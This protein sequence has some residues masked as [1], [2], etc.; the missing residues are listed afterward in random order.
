VITDKKII[1]DEDKLKSELLSLIHAD[2]RVDDQWDQLII[3]FQG[4]H[5]D[6]FSKL[7]HHCSSITEHELRLCAYIKMNLSS[8]DIAKIL[9]I[10]PSSVK[11]CKFRLKRKL[12]FS[13]EIDLNE[14]IK[15]L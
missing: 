3:H 7:K 2:H 15:N 1:N 6:F 9:N 12:K 14:W 13:K 5:Q 11:I 8:K 4:V 10:N